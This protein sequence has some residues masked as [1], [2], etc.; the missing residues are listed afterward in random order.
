MRQI[1]QVPKLRTCVKFDKFQGDSPLE[2]TTSASTSPASQEVP[3]EA[4]NPPEEEDDSCLP[5]DLVGA[6]RQSGEASASFVNS[7]GTRAVERASGT[8]FIH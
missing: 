1:R 5:N 7:G 2:Q 8:S 4:E 3:L 6:V